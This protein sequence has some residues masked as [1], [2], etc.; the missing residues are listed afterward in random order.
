MIQREIKKSNEEPQKK[1]VVS[2]SV[3][4][5]IA[6]TVYHNV[7]P[8]GKRD[9]ITRHEKLIDARPAYRRFKPAQS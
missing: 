6:L 4:K 8:D 7:G 3:R 9:S 5:N 1:F 2:T